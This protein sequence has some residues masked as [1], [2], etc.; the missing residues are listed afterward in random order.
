MPLIYTKIIKGTNAKENNKFVIFSLHTHRGY[1]WRFDS[2]FTS[3]TSLLSAAGCGTTYF[4][5]T[6]R[7]VCTYE[8]AF[9]NDDG[10]ENVLSVPHFLFRCGHTK[11]KIM[12]N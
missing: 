2:S 10:V 9:E 5:I 4:V 1:R 3:S 8:A 12:I 11:M 7:G 6:S